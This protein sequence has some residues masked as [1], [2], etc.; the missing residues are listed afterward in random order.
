MK[1]ILTHENFIF[2]DIFILSQ[3][4]KNFQSISKV[5]FYVFNDN[6]FYTQV[7]SGYVPDNTDAFFLFLL[8]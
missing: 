2:K 1:T 4:S 3:D 6:F 8:Q 7:A 5:T